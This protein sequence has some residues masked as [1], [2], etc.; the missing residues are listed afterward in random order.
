MVK[1]RSLRT[2]QKRTP[3]QK[4]R[5]LGL[6]QTLGKGISTLHQSSQTG[7]GGPQMVVGIGEIRGSP[8]STHLKASLQKALPKTKVENRSLI[9]GIHPHQKAE[10]RLLHLF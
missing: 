4:E 6:G 5:S 8:H 3:H 10:I 9:P 7:Q 2:S 1:M